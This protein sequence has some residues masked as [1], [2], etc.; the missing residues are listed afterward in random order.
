ML[1]DT[2]FIPSAFVTHNGE[3]LDHKTPLLR[4]QDAI[5]KEATRL[6]HNLGDTDVKQV[7]ANVGWEQEYFIVP[8][9]A[10]GARARAPRPRRDP[11]ARALA[12]SRRRRR[13]SRG[14]P[15]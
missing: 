1:G 6:L 8:R 12:L 9:E 10:R 4:A 2:L 7:V 3:A 5:N 11:S 15:I 14:S 13:S